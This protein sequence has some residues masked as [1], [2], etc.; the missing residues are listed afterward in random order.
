[1]NAIKN[2]WLKTDQDLKPILFTGLISMIIGCSIVLTLTGIELT[3]AAIEGT[4]LA[5]GA[6]MVLM[7]LV[8][9]L[10]SMVAGIK[11]L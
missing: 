8:V 1:M 2:N 3:W 10:R 4:L 7:A 11:Q 6:G 9:L 5:I